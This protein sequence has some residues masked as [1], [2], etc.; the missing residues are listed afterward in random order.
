MCFWR[1]VYW[2]A[3]ALQ[4]F[5][6]PEKFWL[7]VCTQALFFLQNAVS[8]IRLCLDYCS[9]IC[10]VTLCYVLHQTH[11]EFWH[12]QAY[13]ELLRHIDACWGIIK[14][15]SGLSRHIHNPEQP[16]YNDNLAI[17]WAL[18]YLEPEACSKPY[19]T[20]T[21]YTHNPAIVRTVYSGIFQ[22]YSGIFRTLRNACICK[23]PAY[24]ESWNIQNPS[25]I[26]SQ[27]IFITLSYLRK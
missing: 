13:S 18:A 22:P 1:N 23:N 14:A 8:W 19:E 4:N 7:C 27:R 12:I 5:P 25:L 10:T 16:S 11:S 26:A 24:S 2:S 21:R 17:F 6:C 3:L 9:L 20:L 15:Y